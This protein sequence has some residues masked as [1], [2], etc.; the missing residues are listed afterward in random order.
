MQAA[1]PAAKSGG[2][3]SYKWTVAFVVI[4][5]MFASIMDATIVNNAIPHL[6]S[7]FGGSLSTVQWVL[8]GYTLA[9]G[10]ATPLT[11]FLAGRMGVKRL[12]LIALA[13]FTICSALC[14]LA[15]NL[16]V[17]IF[18]RL[19]QGAGGALLSP[20]SI[21]LL[22]SVFPPQERGMAMGVLGIPML[23]APALGPTVGG[24]LITFATWR[25]IF[26][27][28]VPLGITGFVL[29]TLLLREVRQDAP[30]HFDW[31][32]FVFV[33]LGLIAVLYA[34][35]RVS[36]EGWGS[37]TVLILIGGG[38]IA[39]LLFALVELD[40]IARGGEP[41]LNLRI[42]GD[43]AF[44]LSML[45]SSVTFFILIGGMFLIPL[46]LQDL[47]GLSAFQ[48]GLILLP[49]AVAS[50]AFALIG[51]RLV[52][53]FGTQPIVLPGLLLMIYPLW[54]LSRVTA[55]TP[56]SWFQ[57]LL[58]MRAIEMGLVMQPLMRAALLRIPARQLTQASSLSTVIRFTISSL[59]TAVLGTYVQT[60]QSVHY[61]NLATQVIP[62]TPM[63]QLISSLQAYL[64]THG[65]D[66]ISAHNAAILEII[67][68]VQ[69]QAYGLAIQDAFRLGLW[70]LIPAF[71]AVLLL[72]AELRTSAKRMKKVAEGSKEQKASEEVP[73]PVMEF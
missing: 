55:T 36:T 5:G 46:Y 18:F 60:Q 38:L 8:T 1:V 11:A 66:L 21:T 51:G 44:S 49:Q 41:L 34:F 52:D 32:G 67:R 57:D 62:G 22:Y 47:R 68:I 65:M 53:R 10:V 30:A 48:T 73:L 16:Q 20:L 61:T 12:Y 26:Y 6:Q 7:T 58:M 4:F 63:G 72:P 3:S 45:A 24:Y 28:N 42:F 39:L 29:G 14:G 25:L 19:M 56:Y 59:S 23:A 69:Q 54:A 64:Q 40:I 17:L 9:Q 35:T 50:I 37:T 2:G 15:W 27:I 13:I 43:R 31:W 70:T 33:T 71:F